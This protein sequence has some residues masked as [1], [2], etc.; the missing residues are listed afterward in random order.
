M[1]VLMGGREK[2]TTLVTSRHSIGNAWLLSGVQCPFYLPV[3]DSDCVCKESADTFN[4]YVRFG[5]LL[6]TK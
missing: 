5:E 3:V 1:K 4:E 2:M 6:F